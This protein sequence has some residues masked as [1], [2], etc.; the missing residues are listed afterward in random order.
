MGNDLQL[1]DLVLAEHQ[2]RHR[3]TK[4]HRKTPKGDTPYSAAYLRD[5]TLV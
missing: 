2:R 1:L 4:R 3:T 5:C